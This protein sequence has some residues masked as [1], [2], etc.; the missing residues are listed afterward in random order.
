MIDQATNFQGGPVWDGRKYVSYFRLSWCPVL[1]ANLAQLKIDH[2]IVHHRVDRKRVQ[3]PPERRGQKGG[4]ARKYWI[5]WQNRSKSRVKMRHSGKT[6]QN[7]SKSA[8]ISK[9][10]KKTGFG[11]PVWHRGGRRN[12]RKCVIFWHFW[13]PGRVYSGPLTTKGF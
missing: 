3:N 11:H 12:A 4:F 5:F 7:Q 9:N 1:V 2:K 10:V 8:K 13:H 6:G